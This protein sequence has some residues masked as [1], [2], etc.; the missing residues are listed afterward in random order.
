M[1]HINIPPESPDNP[2]PWSRWLLRA[3]L[4]GLVG[5]ELA[6]IAW[7]VYKIISPKY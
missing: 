4:I 7:I 6:A 1:V 5:V 2:N 3:V